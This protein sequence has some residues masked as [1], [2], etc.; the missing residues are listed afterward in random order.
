VPPPLSTSRPKEQVGRQG[1]E[2]HLLLPLAVA[3]CHACLLPLV[4]CHSIW[5]RV[6]DAEHEVNPSISAH[7]PIARLI[8]DQTSSSPT[9]PASPL[10]HASQCCGRTVLLSF[11]T[12]HTPSPPRL[13]T[14]PEPGNTTLDGSIGHDW[15]LRQL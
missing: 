7:V 15:T 11:S 10:E 4:T 13:L 8:M 1:D 9:T 12:G 3:A 6:A 14:T 2:T 5:S